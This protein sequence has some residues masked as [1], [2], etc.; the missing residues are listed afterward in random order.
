MVAALLAGTVTAVLSARI[1]GQ[2]MAPTLDDGDRVLMTP[3]VNAKDI[4]RF[5]VVAVRPEPG[6]LPVIKRVIALPGDRVRIRPS[7]GSDPA[8]L[9]S[10][11]GTGDWRRVES[12]AWHGRWADALP[13][14][15]PDGTQGALGTATVPAGTWFVIGDNPGQS[16]DSRTY[17]WV[18][19][20]GLTG[21]MWV[22]VYPLTEAGA[23]VHDFRLVPSPR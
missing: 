8:V 11:A 16:D 20:D 17:G 5:D 22:R 23:L 18:P 13:C 21:R 14:C 3:W 6:G 10:P 15:A 4:R 19:A 2:S 1:D 12:S 7:A 9:V